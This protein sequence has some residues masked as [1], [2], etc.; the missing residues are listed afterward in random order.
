M[1]NIICI[2]LT[3]IISIIVFTILMTLPVILMNLAVTILGYLYPNSSENPQEN[4]K[5]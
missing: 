3:S 5:N 1:N 4:K 2:I